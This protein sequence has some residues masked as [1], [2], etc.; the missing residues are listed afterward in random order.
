MTDDQIK[1]MVG[2]FL[3]WKLPETFAP[4]DV[5]RVGRFSMHVA[6]PVLTTYRPDQA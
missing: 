1:H 2:R 4:D 5:L 6:S 3:S